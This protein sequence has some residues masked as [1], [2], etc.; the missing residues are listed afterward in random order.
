MKVF[1]A[2]MFVLSLGL[3]LVFGLFGRLGS[4][5]FAVHPGLLD[6]TTRFINAYVP[7]GAVHRVLMDALNWPSWTVPLA[8]GVLT[9]L[10]AAGRRR[11]RD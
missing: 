2:S 8:I 4:A 5:L 10:I 6:G 3:M 11:L 7:P 9:V 1:A